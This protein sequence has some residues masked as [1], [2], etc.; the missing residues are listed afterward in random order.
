M[1]QRSPELWLEEQVEDVGT[2]GFFV[3]QQQSRP[4]TRRVAA[5]TVERGAELRWVDRDR[6]GARGQ[7]QRR[8]GCRSGVATGAALIDRSVGVNAGLVAVC[9]VR[10]HPAPYALHK[11][12][13][14][15][16]L[17][18]RTIDAIE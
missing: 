9:I 1:V 15:P 16:P 17:P 12:V 2:H 3:V 8:G 18:R 5:H 7:Q 10:G 11:R 13:R 6:R 4:P 14:R